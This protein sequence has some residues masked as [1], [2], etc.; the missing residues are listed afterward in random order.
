MHFEWAAIKCQGLARETRRG[1]DK[2]GSATSRGGQGQGPWA[3]STVALV[4]TAVMAPRAAGA[5][6]LG[7]ESTMCPGSLGRRRMRMEGAVPRGE[8]QAWRKASG[9]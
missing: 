6:V 2:T 1:R 3:S 9:T 7:T 5:P 8:G 4:G